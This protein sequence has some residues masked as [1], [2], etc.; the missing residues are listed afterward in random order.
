MSWCLSKFSRLVPWEM[1]EEQQGEHAYWNWG[2]N[3]I[4]KYWRPFW[5][6]NNS[7]FITRKCCG[8]KSISHEVCSKRE[9]AMFMSAFN[10][11]N[12]KEI[13]YL[14]FVTQLNTNSRSWQNRNKIRGIT[15]QIIGRLKKRYFSNK[16]LRF[17]YWRRDI[18]SKENYS[19]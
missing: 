8:N 16:T 9:C 14:L 13:M 10:T 5:K 17:N 18:F 15:R 19:F 6:M 3:D 12:K 2:T 11:T 7:H 4:S 1:Y